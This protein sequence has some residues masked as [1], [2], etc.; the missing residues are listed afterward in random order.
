MHVS[1]SSNS[2]QADAKRTRGE[3]RAKQA[4]ATW[5]GLSRC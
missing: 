3:E 2:T 1:K 5:S 4:I